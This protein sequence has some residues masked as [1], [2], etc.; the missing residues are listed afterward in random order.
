MKTPLETYTPESRLY[1]KQE[2]T[3]IR[4]REIAE[5]MA[6]PAILASMMAEANP[7]TIHDL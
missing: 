6:G 3:E 7:D 5:D 1:T 2:L 4:R